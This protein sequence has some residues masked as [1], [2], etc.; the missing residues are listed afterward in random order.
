MERVVTEKNGEGGNREEWRDWKQRRMKRLETE[1]NG[2]G[3]NRE[4]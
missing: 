4:E 3:G 2:E 1:K